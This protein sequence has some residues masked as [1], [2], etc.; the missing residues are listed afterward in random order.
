MMEAATLIAAVIT[1]LGAIAGAVVTA[2]ASTRSRRRRE[3][4][5]EE[6]QRFFREQASEGLRQRLKELGAYTDEV[7]RSL[8]ALGA[9]P[10]TRG[11]HPSKEEVK[12]EVDSAVN[13][14]RER[15]E[16][17]EQRFPEESTLEKI[18]SINDAILATK[19]ERLEKS[20]ENLESTLVTKWDV[21]T[22]VFAVFGAISGVAGVIFTVANFVLN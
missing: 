10:A 16:R 9:P 17:V 5:D 19:I 18:A 7:E 14:I 8:I 20:I 6:R 1:A 22:I 11:T 12:Q 13:V 3:E 15:L 4:A 21:A 2:L